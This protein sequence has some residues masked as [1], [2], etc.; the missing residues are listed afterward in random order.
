MKK[1]FEFLKHK[2]HSNS[3][4]VEKESTYDTL[5]PTILEVE[6]IQTYISAINEAVGDSR[7]KNIAITGAYGS[8]KSSI[9]QT[10][11]SI[12]PKEKFLNISLANFKVDKL[13][14]EDSKQTSPEENNL[15]RLLELSI[16]QQIFYH[17]KKSEIPD[18]R[19]KRI[20]SLSSK[21][22]I[23]FVLIVLVWLVSYTILFHFPVI[24]E[25]FPE[26]IYSKSLMITA[27]IIF[28]TG[29]GLGLGNLRRVFNNS[30]INKFNIQSGDF[31]IDK[32][33]DRSIINKHLDEIIYFFQVTDHRLV[34][35]E[36]LDR[37]NNTE[38]FSKLREINLL[39]N[40]SEQIEKS[41]KPI[42]FIY[43]I[44]DDMFVDRDRVKFFDF[45]IPIIPIINPSNSGDILL[46]KLATLDSSR[47]PSEELVQGISYFIDDM[48]L[49]K[50]IW[51]EYLTYRN[52]L[53][54]SLSQDKLFSI[55]TYKN[56]YPDD[57]VALHTNKSDISKIFERRKS[58]EQNLIDQLDNE[59]TISRD[60]LN[61]ID[62]Q[63]INDLDELKKI[64]IATL[65]EMYPGSI[66]FGI[67]GTVFTFNEL[68]KDENF[69][70]LIST[71]SILKI[72]SPSIQYDRN[73][74]IYKGD[75]SNRDEDFSFSTFEKKVN[76]KLS[77]ENRQKLI[78]KDY[79]Y[80][81]NFV[82]KIAALQEK[83]KVIKNYDLRQLLIELDAKEIL[84]E[85][86]SN[87]LLIYIIT[88]GYVDK[89]YAEYIS[90]FH[91]VS[92]SSMDFDFL[93][94]LRSGVA[95][96]FDFELK[97][98]GNLA[99]KVESKYFDTRPI[100]NYQLFDFWFANDKY[101]IQQKSI[102]SLLATDF[103]ERTD[104]INGIIEY[105][106]QVNNFSRICI[107]NWNGF[108]KH[109]E[110]NSAYTEDLAEIYFKNIIVQGG[111]KDIIQQSNHSSL[112]DY[113]ESK[114]GFLSLFPETE[115]FGKMEDVIDELQIEFE[116]ISLVR[117]DLM[118]FIYETNR[119]KINEHNLKTMLSY[120]NEKESLT[121]FDISNS[122]LKTLKENIEVEID[123][124]VQNVLLDAN[125]LFNEPDKGFINLINHSKLS[126]DL[127]VSL[128]KKFEK[129]IPH[130]DQ[131]EEIEIMDSLIENNKVSPSW[132]NV[133]L[134]F[135]KY[136]G[137]I[138]PSLTEFL[139]RKEVYTALDKSK[140]RDT[141]S[142]KTHRL[143]LV[144]K[145]LVNDDLD[146]E[147]Y[148]SLLSPTYFIFSEINL[149]EISEKKV[150]WVIQNKYAKT[151]KNNF[152][153]L[154]ANF[155]DEH[156]HLAEVQATDFLREIEVYA[157]DDNDILALLKSKSLNLKDKIIV[158]QK[159]VDSSLIG[160]TTG[161]AEVVSQI[162]V[163]AK[164]KTNYEILTSLFAITKS[165]ELRVKLININFVELSDS[166]TFEL[167]RQMPE[168]YKK[169][170]VNYKRPLLIKN[171][172]NRS[173]A[174]NLKRSDLISSFSE[175]K[176]GIRIIANYS[177]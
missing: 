31:E 72:S 38:I 126:Q 118:N 89:Y 145:L 133:L 64:Y 139:G 166:N 99:E 71:K 24:A 169:I 7:N 170:P 173:F 36:D 165:V 127:K 42:V 73:Y 51:N 159:Q 137:L 168:P 94:A 110:E 172:Y 39:L 132:P 56:F 146:F 49:L 68:Y 40:N 25:W 58:F 1:L 34:V 85:Y 77:Y 4:L 20:N 59:I 2:K 48:R 10:Y 70:K 15:N 33:I 84:K 142:D 158:F 131:I 55:I 45:I 107:A 153:Y 116:N 41:K 53:K 157:L 43:A 5:S 102:I 19:F 138:N 136:E 117:N 122:P 75:M 44:R 74:Q 32:D 135:N 164:L 176:K 63:R 105:S 104:F 161:M 100:L 156:I 66:A 98:I 57:F 6:E 115:N 125:E 177:D 148:K 79:S 123:E 149:D 3:N 62:R 113:I 83:K 22:I 151:T 13:D 154:K 82:S 12:N 54:H 162:L 88:N 95:F 144:K 167:I 155:P 160:R 171:D 11:Q 129:T 150:H 121:Y 163:D 16:L 103:I 97:N 152:D 17:V 21:S 140:M 109:L 90:Y 69:D 28:L 52:I 67:S 91:E 27:A 65:F 9:L 37:F 124:Y 128:I 30:K 93:L 47:R 147:A 80:R 108:W 106:T 60:E 14:P 111:L 143:E 119:Y 175:D 96:A 35:I 78:N 29:I 81:D 174:E 46:K 92:L 120:K 26:I 8:G 50:N 86:N 87:K 18:S 112:K 23:G 134:Y 76:N 101:T 130:L 61:K 114:D 141:I